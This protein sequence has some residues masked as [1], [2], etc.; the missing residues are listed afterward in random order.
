MPVARRRY[1]E[2][3]AS[4]YGRILFIAVI[5]WH[6]SLFSIVGLNALVFDRHSGIYV[7][8]GPLFLILG[9]YGIAG[10]CIQVFFVEPQMKPFAVEGR[11]IGMTLG[12]PIGVLFWVFFFVFDGVSLVLGL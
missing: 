11:T 1:L 8:A 6:I 4:Q 2:A 12:I 3:A 5:W 10:V 9:G 7:G